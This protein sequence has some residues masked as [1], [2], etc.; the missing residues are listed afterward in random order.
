MAE[1]TAKSGPL[2]VGPNE[3][4]APDT[5]AG[6]VWWPGKTP[7]SA[8]T[9]MGLV[10]AGETAPSDITRLRDAAG[11]QILPATKAGGV[12]T[13]AGET[14]EAALNAL[15]MS[16]AG[17]RP[18]V[19]GT[20]PVSPGQAITAGD[21]VDVQED[22]SVGKT[23]V[24][25][26]NVE[27]TFRSA[28]SSYIDVIALTTST[29]VVVCGSPQPITCYA[30]IKDSSGKM[31]VGGNVS[32]MSGA[33]SF[34]SLVRLSSLA[35]ALVYKNELT[36]SIYACVGT[37]SGASISMGAQIEISSAGDRNALIPI[38]ENAFLTVFNRSGLK[39]K[40]CTISGTTI[41]QGA[42]A[43]L[44]GST[45]ASCLSTTRLP[46]L[47]GNKRVCVCFS[48]SGDGNKGKAVIAT[49]SSANAVTWGTVVTIVGSQIYSTDCCTIGNTVLFMY[50]T[51][52]SSSVCSL[53]VTGNT[54]TKGAAAN[55]GGNI[56]TSGYSVAI[57][58]VGDKA[59]CL[60]GSTASSIA[61]VVKISGGNLTVGQQ[62]EFNPAGAL[63]K[64]VDSVSE[65]QII[66]CYADAGNSNY[67]TATTLE[68]FGDRIAGSFEDRSSQA[69]ALQS[70]NAG[71]DCEVIFE[72][73]AELPGITAGQEIASPGVYG[74][75]PMDGVLWVKPEWDA[76]FIA[77][78]YIGTGSYGK[79]G[80][81][82]LTFS[83]PVQFVIIQ[84]EGNVLLFLRGITK[85]YT[86]FSSTAY[87]QVSIM[88]EET[89]V[90]WYVGNSGG[91]GTQMN[92]NGQTYK[93]LA[94]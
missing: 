6:Q 59:V 19:T 27:T 93:Y 73:V 67:G 49:I 40:V 23:M 81:N 90:T 48:D 18:N 87:N 26:G 20:Y 72:G 68:V 21:V 10:C 9:D 76:T 79:D 45:S 91:S 16:V 64:S 43:A 47:N 13:E 8:L 31:T 84:T 17:K 29:F 33:A 1:T 55:T 37:I 52:G 5:W 56:T 4:F 71:Q 2:M 94:V 75:C 7:P 36:N 66:S 63:Y 42:E 85:Q 11:K 34:A 69:I 44:T 28:S 32:P 92:T 86:D 83:R 39:A 35:F 15:G 30:L 24:P 53:T 54:I 46:D 89:S 80:P 50:G 14:V 3:Q 65:N 77:G 88:W 58:A 12:S 38:A 22:G 41:A 25:G 57:T 70:A 51:S 74:Y 78:S 60:L 82:K 61:K 62:Y